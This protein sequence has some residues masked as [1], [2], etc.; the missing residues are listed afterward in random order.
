M[1]LMDDHAVVYEVEMHNWKWNIFFVSKFNI[2][3]TSSSSFTL[4]S[5]C[6]GSLM[7]SCITSN[8]DI[9]NYFVTWNPIDD[10]S[11]ISI[12][13]NHLILK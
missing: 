12:T 7:F 13:T 8:L 2:G 5:E 11:H 1:A 9:V 6:L 4:L 3:N 10:E